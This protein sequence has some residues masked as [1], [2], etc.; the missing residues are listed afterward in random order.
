MSPL[1]FLQGFLN[2]ERWK[3]VQYTVCTMYIIKYVI[4]QCTKYLSTA[5]VPVLCSRVFKIFYTTRVHKVVYITSDFSFMNTFWI[6]GVYACGHKI[7]P[8]V[9]EVIKICH[10]FASLTLGIV[11]WPLETRG[12]YFMTTGITSYYIKRVHK[13]N[14]PRDINHFMIPSYINSFTTTYSMV[15]S[16]VPIFRSVKYYRTK[17]LS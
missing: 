12:K 8:L 15:K 17:G 14:I 7:F 2:F 16:L 6:K 5:Q 11:L 10:S 4:V 9:L 1:H 3:C 13:R